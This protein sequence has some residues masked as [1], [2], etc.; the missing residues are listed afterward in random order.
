MFVIIGS[1]ELLE[2]EWSWKLWNSFQ[3]ASDLIISIFTIFCLTVLCRWE[4]PQRTR[5]SALK[6]CLKDYQ[7]FKLFNEWQSWGYPKLLPLLYV[8]GDRTL[9]QLFAKQARCPGRCR[10]RCYLGRLSR[11]MA[12]PTSKI[13][14]AVLRGFTYSVIKVSSFQFINLFLSGTKPSMMIKDYFILK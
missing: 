2:N 14:A 3:I 13:L 6:R 8:R 5:L 12:A 11:L 7:R 1:I 10:T 4:L 9:A